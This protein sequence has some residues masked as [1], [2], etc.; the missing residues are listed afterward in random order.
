MVGYNQQR[1]LRKKFQC[2]PSSSAVYF[3]TNVV[4]C[5]GRVVC[6]VGLV[7]TLTEC[8]SV[9]TIPHNWIKVFVAE[10]MSCGIPM[11]RVGASKRAEF[12]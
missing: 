8:V 1:V 2:S 9:A 12:M 7:T 4:S 11:D 10:A 5:V 3:L 6:T